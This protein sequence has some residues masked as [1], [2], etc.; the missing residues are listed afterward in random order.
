MS[1]FSTFGSG[2]TYDMGGGAVIGM[3][4]L[5]GNDGYTYAAQFTPSISALLSSIDVGAYNNAGD[6][7]LLLYLTT[8]N[9]GLPGSTIESF[10]VSGVTTPAIYSVDSV[11]HDWLSAGTN[12]WLVVAAP[13]PVN[14]ISVWDDSQPV[15]TGNNAFS[16]GTG[17]WVH[18]TNGIAPAFRILGDA[19]TSVPEPGT[20]ALLIG[21]LAAVSL[22]AR[23]VR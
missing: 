16:L 6:H 18:S 23:A 7:S 13:D 15:L 21:A 14:D 19:G 20:F 22:R 1:V 10:T 2:D 11:Q 5:V 8:D 17:S 9:S 3:G 12:Y 4:A